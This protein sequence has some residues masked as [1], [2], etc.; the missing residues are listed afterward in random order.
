MRRTYSARTV[1]YYSVLGAAVA[2][3]VRLPAGEAPGLPKDI[4]P[5][6]GELDKKM[7]EM[8]KAAE[9]YRGLPAKQSVPCGS[10]DRELLNKKPWRMSC[11]PTR[12]PLWKPA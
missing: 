5:L 9:E 10:I 1:L 12:W 11:P 3:L 2:L 6:T 7:H 8:L 4:T